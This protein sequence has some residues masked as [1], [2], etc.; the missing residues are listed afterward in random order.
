MNSPQRWDA[1]SNPL[2]ACG[3]LFK[4]LSD[5]IDRPNPHQ[6]RP[7]AL[8]LDLG[9][10]YFF[11]RYSQPDPI[12]IRKVLLLLLRGGAEG[13]SALRRMRSEAQPARPLGRTLLFFQRCTGIDTCFTSSLNT[14]FSCF[15]IG[16]TRKVRWKYAE[17]LESVRGGP[18]SCTR[19]VHFSVRGTSSEN[20]LFQ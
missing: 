3:C 13:R 14:C 1:S 17:G 16:G 5:G 9:W 20:G 10:V 11:S 7:E 8:L 2:Q 6:P 15:Y 12:F 19:K 18:T 4:Q